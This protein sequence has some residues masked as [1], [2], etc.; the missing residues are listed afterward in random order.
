MMNPRGLLESEAGRIK[1]KFGNNAMR[2]QRGTLS[3]CGFTKESWMFW[4]LKCFLHRLLVSPDAPRS[5]TEEASSPIQENRVDVS[6]SLSPPGY[7][8]L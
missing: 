6:Q 5:I 8:V 2:Q 7:A 3:L 1:N 4:G